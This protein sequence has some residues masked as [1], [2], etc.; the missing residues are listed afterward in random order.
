MC[1]PLKVMSGSFPR[2]CLLI[3]DMH[4]KQCLIG[5]RFLSVDFEA[6]MRARGMNEVARGACRVV[7]PA[8]GL[9]SARHVVCTGVAH[10]GGLP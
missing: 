10:G 1:T 5:V 9:T 8:G 4:A 6:N 2:V 3:P 7:Y